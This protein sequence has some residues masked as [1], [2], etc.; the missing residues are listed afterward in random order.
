MYRSG[1]YSNL[2]R[3]VSHSKKNTLIC[4]YLK[5]CF[6]DYKV[7]LFERGAFKIKDLVWEIFVTKRKRNLRRIGLANLLLLGN[8]SFNTAAVKYAKAS[9]SKTLLNIWKEKLQAY[10]CEEEE[11]EPPIY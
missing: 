7:Q 4:L 1:V 3:T 9:F 2:Y 5:I 11:I 10:Y 8:V 6:S